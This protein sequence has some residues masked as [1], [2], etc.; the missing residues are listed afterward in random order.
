MR[1]CDS[2]LFLIVTYIS[3]KWLLGQEKYRTGLDLV[4]WELIGSLDHCHLHL[5]I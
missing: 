1:S 3:V 4:H 2:L 5:V